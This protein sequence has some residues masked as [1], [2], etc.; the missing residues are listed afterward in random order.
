MK[1]A[2]LKR[3]KLK[4]LIF[5]IVTSLLII[6]IGNTDATIEISKIQN[7]Q[8][9]EI[10]AQII[11]NSIPTI[12]GNDNTSYWAVIIVVGGGRGYRHHALWGIRTANGLMNVLINH[13]WQKNKIKCLIEKEAA[14]DAIFDTFQWLNDSG[15]DEDDVILFCFIG[16]GYNHTEDQ[17]PLDE[18]DGKD[19]CY[20]PWDDKVNSWSW[21]TYILDDELETKFDTLKSKNIVAIFDTCLSG[22]WIDGTSDPCKSGRIILTSCAVD[23]ASAPII[24]RMHWLFTHYLIQGLKGRADKNNDKFV[25]AEEAFSYAKLPTIIRSTIFN[26]IVY[27]IEPVPLTQHPQLYDGW[28]TSDNNHQDLNIINL[29]KKK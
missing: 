20:F 21:D 10:D 2:K 9:D 8:K 19:D 1:T 23:E 6:N 5:L 22:G 12:S 18:P 29:T 24:A 14:K 17:P 28:P 3:L 16:H 25:S 7:N 11:S 26:L 13:G 15:E 4:L 27:L